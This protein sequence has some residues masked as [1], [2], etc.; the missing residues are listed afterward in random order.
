MPSIKEKERKSV[1]LE[2]KLKLLR[3]MEN[4]GK[5]TIEILGSQN[6][7]RTIFFK[8]ANKLK[9]PTKVQHLIQQNFLFQ[10]PLL[11]SF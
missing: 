4:G 7:L 3:R 8:I 6:R 1:T 11:S 2:S 5:A 10:D 9:L